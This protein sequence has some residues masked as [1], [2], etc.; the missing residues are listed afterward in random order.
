[1][2]ADGSTI[3][4]STAD[5]L[6]VDQAF[7]DEDESLD[8]YRAQVDEAGNLTLEL[9]T[10]KSD[11]SVSNDDGCEPVGVPNSWNAI[12][13]EEGKCN[14]VPFAGGA[15]L[16]TGDGALFFVSPEQLEPGKG[17]QNQANLY[18]VRPGGS[19]APH[20]VAL[21]DNSL[22]KPG[23]GPT[24]RPLVTK[25]FGGREFMFP[26][27]LTVDQSDQDVYALEVGF[28]EGNLYRYHA[29]G[30]PD[31]FSAGPGAHTN[32][33]EVS[34]TELG[35]SNQMAVD[36]SPA[37]VG[38][39]LENAVYMPLSSGV[40]VIA[41]SGE[42]LGL[43][44]GTGTSGGAFGRACGVAVNQSTGAVYVADHN[45]HIWQYTP[46][47]PTGGISDSDYTLK[48]IATPGVSPCAIAADTL[49][50]VYAANIKKNSSARPERCTAG[51]Q[52]ASRPEARPASPARKSRRGARHSQPTR[53]PTNSTWTPAKKSR[54]WIQAEP[55]WR[56]KSVSKAP[57]NSSA[58]PIS[59]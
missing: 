5:G 49:G 4:L 37:D 46:N 30:T 19:P 52:A 13:G 51:R 47:G 58:R 7:N 23:P 39:P 54:S 12:E 44:T 3:Y 29:D 42:T 38:G 18:V 50:N 43:I 14:A 10:V 1:M 33:L 34:F 6:P 32:H 16:A 26:G 40:R 45:G 22:E 48:G 53:A 28:G 59:S 55:W 41:Q 36:N 20:F 25:E 9:V 27:E 31:N 11:G 24:Q 35:S 8:I 17:I 2:T 15:G 56:K 57:A 21:L